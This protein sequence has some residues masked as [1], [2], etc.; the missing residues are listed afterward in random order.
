MADDEGKAK[1]HFANEPSPGELLRAAR[2]KKKLDTKEV[3]AT[4]NVDPWMLDALEHDEYGALGAPVFAKGHLRK[5]AAALGLNGDDL[6]VAYYQRDG[7]RE[8]PPLVAES[9]MR[10][11]AANGPRIAWLAPAAGVLALAIV[12]LGVFLYLQPNRGAENARA[13]TAVDVPESTVMT[14]DARS[15]T[16]RLPGAGVSPEPDAKS[17]ARTSTTPPV[18]APATTTAATE[19]QPE[20]VSRAP[21]RAPAQTPPPKPAPVVVEPADIEPAPVRVAR[22]STPQSEPTSAA[23]V[24]IALSFR[25]ESWVEVY[26]GKRGKLLYGLGEEGTTRTLEG[27]A[28]I[29]VFLGK[30]SEV[31]VSV[32]GRPYAVPRVSRSGTARFDVDAPAQ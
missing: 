15:T 18:S 5:Y 28:P 11:E 16:L 31:D 10:V 20:P 30:A 9:I 8:A 32:N 1:G 3:A 7:T 2:L 29:N 24:T 27:A 19:P 6:M 14:D 25:G 12:A 26:D 22:A 4:L 23:P 13:A 17:D 21:Q